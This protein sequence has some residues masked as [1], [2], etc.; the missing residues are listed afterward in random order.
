MRGNPWKS[1]LCSI[2]TR[3][4]GASGH[5]QNN[6]QIKKKKKREVGKE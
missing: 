4:V 1:F 3:E 5:L 2:P 6:I